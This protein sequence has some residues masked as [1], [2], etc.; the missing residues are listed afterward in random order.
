MGFHV[1]DIFYCHILIIVSCDMQ[2]EDVDSH[3]LMGKILIWDH[4]KTWCVECE[5]QNIHCKFCS[6]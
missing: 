3:M 2:F 6:S 4:E 5:F 1:Y